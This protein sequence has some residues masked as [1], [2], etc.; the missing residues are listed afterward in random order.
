MN[1]AIDGRTL[2]G[3]FT[4]D[5]TYWRNLIRALAN[6]FPGD[7]IRVYSRTPIPD[8]ELPDAPNVRARII[9][10]AND[11]IWTLAVLPSRLRQERPDV[12]HVQYTIPPQCPCPVVTTVHDISFRLFPEW[13]PLRHRVLLNLTVPRSMRR[14]A[15]VITDSESSWQDMMREY[16][17]PEAHLVAIPLGLPYE[18]ESAMTAANATGAAIGKEA[19]QQAVRKKYGSATPS[20]LTKP[21]VLAVGVL[22]PRKNLPLLASAFG[23][24]KAKYGLPHQ[25]LFVGKM[26]WGADDALLRGLARDGE[27]AGGGTAHDD[28]LVFPGYVPDEDLPLLYRACDVFAHPALYEGFG[29]PPLEALACGAPCLVSS[30]PAMPEVVGD[31]A[32]TA[33]PR[34]VDAWAE[35]L[36]RLLTDTDLRADLSRRGPERAGLF[37]WETTARLTRQ[38]YLEAANRK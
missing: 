15:R 38:I 33:D 7:D 9:P 18:F 5:R 14:A 4:G 11:R 22:Q 10:A 29:I 26:G 2:T 23:R 8:G 17:L 35:A 37:S 32:L 34:N 20:G 13:F 30:A 3:R 36:G 31:A 27:I 19:A 16:R 1:I 24:A 21:F 25:L 12:L 28:A 6:G